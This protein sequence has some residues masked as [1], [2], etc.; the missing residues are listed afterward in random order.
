MKKLKI[1]NKIL[2]ISFAILAFFVVSEIDFNPAKAMRTEQGNKTVTYFFG[3]DEN[4]NKY[5]HQTIE[6][7]LVIEK[8]VSVAECAFA[9]TIIKGDV[10]IKEGVHLNRWAFKSARIDGNVTL[11]ANTEV[12]FQTFVSS[13]IRG[14]ITIHNVYSHSPTFEMALVWG[15]VTLKQDVHHSRFSRPLFAYTIILGSVI[16]EEGAYI[17]SRAFSCSEINHLIDNRIDGKAFEDIIIYH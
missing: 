3:Q 11:E 2:S 12:G 5:T 8:G 14:N 7:N 9:S 17:S 13:V 6:G 1:G 10:T 16:V 4:E 15:N